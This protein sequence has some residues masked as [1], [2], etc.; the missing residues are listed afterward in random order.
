MANDYEVHKRWNSWLG[1]VKVERRSGTRGRR[2]LIIVCLHTPQIYET[3]AA[4]KT[5]HNFSALMNLGLAS[6]KRRETQPALHTRL[7]RAL[8]TLLGLERRRQARANR[9]VLNVLIIPSSADC[10][11][12]KAYLQNLLRNDNL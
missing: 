8:Y 3:Q 7:L 6:S 10:L 1:Q 5:W 12:T 4:F 9:P 11:A 2:T